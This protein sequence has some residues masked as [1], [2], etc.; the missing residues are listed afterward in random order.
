[1]CA[2]CHHIL[3]CTHKYNLSGDTDTFAKMIFSF[4]SCT[5]GKKNTLL[6]GIIEMDETYVGGKPR[7]DNIR[8]TEYE[9]DSFNKRGRESE[10]TPVLGMVERKGSVHAEK[11][12]NP[13]KYEIDKDDRGEYRL[14]AKYPYNR[15][16]PVLQEYRRL[17][18][19]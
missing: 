15:R 3:S 12:D 17:Y 2:S 8:K 13:N 1:M 6:Q 16:K 5:R 10:K 14:E 4:V 11:T 9:K 7:K 19:S 18:V